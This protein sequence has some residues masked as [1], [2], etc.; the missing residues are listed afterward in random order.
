MWDIFLSGNDAFRRIGVGL[1]V[2]RTK[3][4]GAAEPARAATASRPIGLWLTHTIG[5]LLDLGA[6]IAVP[7]LLGWYCCNCGKKHP[8][9]DN[10]LLHTR[11]FNF[12]SRWMRPH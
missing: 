4:D 8:A 12:R 7:P 11:S 5:R 1:L 2:V 9:Q 3:L 6:T 10:A